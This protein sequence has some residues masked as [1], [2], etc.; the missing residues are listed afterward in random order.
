MPQAMH[1]NIAEMATSGKL[2]VLAAVSDV[3]S[4]VCFQFVINRFQLERFNHSSPV[5]QFY[6]T[7][8][9]AAKELKKSEILWE[10]YQFAWLD[11]ADIIR[12]IAMTKMDE[13]AIIVFNYSTYEFFL[14]FDEPEK[15]TSQSIITWLEQLSDG[16]SG[17]S[18][19]PMGGRGWTTRIRRI[20]YD[21]YTNVA[22]MFASQPLLSCCLFGVPIAFL[23]IICYRFDFPLLCSIKILVFVRRILLWNVT[24]SIQMRRRKKF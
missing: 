6:K 16:I 9:T 22:Q 14:P 10:Q 3:S 2:L 24:N 4:L 20:I 12:G 7:V 11:G 19:T 21:V 5:G 15:M 1:S 8:E 18:I 13:P 23:S 17:G